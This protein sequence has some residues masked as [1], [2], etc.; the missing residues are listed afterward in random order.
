MKGLITVRDFGTPAWVH[1]KRAASEVAKAVRAKTWVRWTFRV[2]KDLA[3]PEGFQ[4]PE[5]WFSAGKKVFA[6][7]MAS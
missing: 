7:R 5:G 4:A 6:V 3:V 1:T 2:P